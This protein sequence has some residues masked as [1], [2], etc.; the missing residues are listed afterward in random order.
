VVGEV[1]DE[2]A[3]VL[4]K[5]MIPGSAGLFSTVPDLLI[6]L[7]MLLNQ[8]VHGNQRYFS[9][10]IIK[11]MG[12]NQLGIAGASAGLGWEYDQ[13]RY[14]GRYSSE[15]FGKTGFTG[16][17]VMINI[18]RGRAF[19][20]LSNFTYPHRKASVEPMQALRRDL[21]DMVFAD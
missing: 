12:T 20:L 5:V 1:H 13:G 11:A 4:Q 10:S 18:K 9:E 14:M 7:Q 16:C 6:F 2:S 15:V 17:V 19:S 8:G 21:A 3:W